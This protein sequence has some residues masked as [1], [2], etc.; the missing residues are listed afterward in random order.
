MQQ[1]LN[2]SV[3]DLTAFIAAI[4]FHW[5]IELNRTDWFTYQ[6]FPFHDAEMN[7]KIDQTRRRILQK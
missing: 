1:V 4:I 7:Q 6:L 3:R 5:I 2:H